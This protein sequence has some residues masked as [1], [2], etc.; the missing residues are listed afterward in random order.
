[1]SYFLLPR[2]HNIYTVDPLI[3]KNIESINPYISF[4]LI[5]YLNDVIR[6]IKNIEIESSFYYD[7][8]KKIINPYDF[9]FSKVPDYY[10]SVS[11][12]NTNSNIFYILY[13]LS[14]TFSI[15]DLFEERNIRNKYFTNN[16]NYTSIKEC[17]ELLRKKQDKIDDFYS[18]E[19]LDISSFST[20][21][22][23]IE[24][25]ESIDLLFFEID[26]LNNNENLNKYI[27]E[28]ITII[29]KILQYQRTSG[30][31]II[32]VDILYHKPILDTLFLLTLFYEKIYIIKPNFS[33]V[34]SNERYLICK[35][36]IT[37]NEL[38]DQYIIQLNNLLTEYY[39]YN[40]KIENVIIS[41]LFKENLPNYFL[42]K[43]EESNII[44]GHQQ[45]ENMDQIL[46][47]YKNNFKDDKFEILIKQNIQK[48]VQW[49]EKQNIPHYIF[50]EKSN[51]FKHDED[52]ENDLNPFL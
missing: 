46:N 37:N 12:I 44:I 7:L 10:Y 15:L 6:K 23:L 21:D 9:L 38:I 27:I 13:E 40:T 39:N 50:F 25:K 45:I 2:K 47:I 35:N 34:L 52:V 16:I 32:K 26:K 17:I 28:F 24:D 51:I 8:I 43:I 36:F 1:M 20:N 48:C 49:C 30:L 11:K 14:Y 18:H 42:N 19:L 22:N 4:S 33:N 41:R 5:Y 31:C 3:I 29:I